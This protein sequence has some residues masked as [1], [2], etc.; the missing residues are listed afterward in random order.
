MRCAHLNDA[1][2]VTSENRKTIFRRPD[3]VILAVPDRVATAVCTEK[4]VKERL[5]DFLL[6]IYSR[7]PADHLPINNATTS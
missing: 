5:R 3:H 2:D 7:K 4:A 6:E 1:P